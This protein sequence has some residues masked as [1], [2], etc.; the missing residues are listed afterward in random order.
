MDEVQNPQK[1]KDVKLILTFD[2]MPNAF[3]D[4]AAVSPK[5]YFEVDQKAKEYLA[6]QFN[7]I[8]VICE[9]FKSP[10]L[11]NLLDMENMVIDVQTFLVDD[12][13]YANMEKAF[14]MRGNLEGTW[15]T[16]GPSQYKMQPKC[17]QKQISRYHNFAGK[18]NLILYAAWLQNYANIET[19]ISVLAE[20]TGSKYAAYPICYPLF[21]YQKSDVAFL[22]S[23]T[24]TGRDKVRTVID[25]V[26]ASEVA[27]IFPA[28]EEKTLFGQDN[29]IAT[30]NCP[31]LGPLDLTPRPNLQLDDKN[32][33]N[34]Y[35]LANHHQ[36]C[37]NCYLYTNNYIFSIESKKD[38]IRNIRKVRKL[39]RYE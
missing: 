36:F 32:C 18:L 35:P 31:Y 24:Q 34:C 22:E 29:H 8:R 16:S 2:G 21:F 39:L 30:D 37:Y 20:L 19:D 15:I 25:R 4:M 7:M 33:S 17:W 38:Y 12:E 14:S 23:L 9:G 27:D 3:A 6:K 10:E 1:E 26:F 13:A 28:R 5:V 11:F